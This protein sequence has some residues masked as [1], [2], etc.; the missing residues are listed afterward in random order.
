MG[1]E[2]TIEIKVFCLK[3]DVIASWRTTIKTTCKVAKYNLQG[4]LL[5]Q[6]FPKIYTLLLHH[7]CSQMADSN[8]N[9]ATLAL[10]KRLRI[11]LQLY[12]HI[13]IHASFL[14]ETT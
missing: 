12:S 7:Y 4:F 2:L 1:V 6:R 3:A 10:S 14:R 9:S 8:V 11:Y 13:V 5:L